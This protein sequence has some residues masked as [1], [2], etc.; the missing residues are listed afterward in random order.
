MFED[1]FGWANVYL[2]LLLLVAS[3][4]YGNNIC[5]N[6][7][8]GNFNFALL[9]PL[10]VNILDIFTSAT[11]CEKCVMQHQKIKFEPKS[12]FAVNHELVVGVS[13]DFDK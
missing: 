4:F 3:I 13:I 8:K 12:F 11:T 1:I 10:F 9:I 7:A 6:Y 5:V 2:I